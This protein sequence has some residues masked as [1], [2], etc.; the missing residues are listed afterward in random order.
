MNRFLTVGRLHLTVAVLIAF[1]FLGS[2]CQDSAS[3]SDGPPV[4]LSSLTVT[5][6]GTIQPA[7]SP[8]VTDYQATVSTTDDSVVVRA[9]PETSTSTM[10][11]DGQP[12][13]ADQGITVALGPPPSTK[14][15]SIRLTDPSGT[16]T[17]YVATVIRPASSN[18]D[19]RNLTVSPGALNPTFRAGTTRYTVNVGSGTSSVRVNAVLQDTNSTLRIDGQDA[20]SGQARTI[21][22][23]APGSSRDISILVT[24]PS[25]AQKVY[26]VT[27]MKAALG[28]NSNLRSLIVSPGPLNPAFR[29]DTTRYELN[30]GSGTSRVR[31][32]AALED[33]NGTLE[34]NQ[35]GTSSGQARTIDLGAPG[36]TT[37]IEVL[38]I[39]PNGS[40]KRYLVEV[41]RAALSSDNNLSNIEV[42]PSTLDPAFS[43]GTTQYV[44]EVRTAVTEVTVTATKSDPNAV[45]SGD[46]PNQGQA[47]ITLGGPGTSETVSITVTAPNGSSKTYTIRVDRAA[48]ASDNNLSLLTVIPGGLSPG[49]SPNT[50]SYEVVS[51]AA[52]ASVSATKSDPD[53]VMSGSVTAGAGVPT[54]SATIQL[55]GP[56]ESTRITITVTAPNGRSKTYAITVN[57]PVR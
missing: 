20:A 23:G 37:E 43:A 53:A 28:G 47:T 26:T 40:S 31:V 49:F 32:T 45:I 9:S 17:T 50:L 56:G 14:N 25:G 44:V 36:S 42:S 12:A 30:V 10:T 18:S 54:G 7:F 24:A 2:G 4:R 38:A 27:V 1:G 33:T 46:L 15:I 13:S 11:I 16:Q 6:P 48:P 34:I 3:V 51:G 5:P 57:R 39:A 41:S 35:Q 19:L 22:L 52:S 8:D 29:T 21:D 55:G